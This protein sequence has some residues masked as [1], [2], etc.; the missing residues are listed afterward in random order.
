MG[1]PGNHSESFVKLEKG[2]SLRS[3]L[4]GRSIVEFPVLHVALPKEVGRYTTVQISQ[5]VAKG[6]ENDAGRRL[7]AASRAS[8]G[9]APPSPVEESSYE[10]ESGASSD[11]QPSGIAPAPPPLPEATGRPIVRTPNQRPPPPPP[12]DAHDR[13]PRRQ[14]SMDALDSIPRGRTPCPPP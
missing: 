1:A 11:D 5:A 14:F 2:R 13:T 7:D 6:S 4:E 12:S 9:G 8:N 10:S 3:N